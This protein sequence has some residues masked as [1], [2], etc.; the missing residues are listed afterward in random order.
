MTT[1][2]DAVTASNIPKDA[3]AVAGYVNGK[4]RWS[5]ADWARF[6]DATKVHIQIYIPGEP[7]SNAGH[8]LDIEASD[9]GSAAAQAAAVKWVKARNAAG[10]SPPVIYT[11]RSTRPAIEKALKKEGLTAQ[12][13][14]ADYTGKPHEVP[15]AVATQWMVGKGYDKSTVKKSWLDQLRSGGSKGGSGGGSGGAGKKKP[16]AKPGTDRTAWR[17]PRNTAGGAGKIVIDTDYLLQLSRSLTGHLATVESVR[18]TTH[19]YEQ[20]VAKLRLSD[21][22]Q[23]RRIRQG[24]AAA[25]SDDHGVGRVRWL[26]VRDLGYVIEARERALGADRT[27]AQHKR[28][29]ESLVASV[30]GGTT[31]AGKR[32]L[33]RLLAGLAPAPSKGGSSTGGGSGSK[34]PRGSKPRGPKN[35]S[36]T[37][38]LDDVSKGKAWGGSMAPF[39]QLINPFLAKRGLKAGSAKRGAQ[40]TATGGVSDHWTGKKDAYATDYPTMNGE[41]P[42][43]ELARALGIKGWRPGSYDTYNV[44][45]GGR[46]FR[47]QILWAVPGHFDHVHVGLQRVS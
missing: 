45:I 42:A 26:M 28:V 32:K 44:K 4:Y 43:R 41:G 37:R 33:Q 23:V 34:G 5:E 10:G 39:T 35:P 11:S 8:V 29:L 21:Q 3:D 18:R 14:I 6:P 19:A 13:W 24:L 47:T 9:A 17:L 30:G 27:D 1:M 40:G 31:K 15:G 46:T 2:Y 22:D 20:E 7:V 38:D 36:G 25:V 12:W 16:E